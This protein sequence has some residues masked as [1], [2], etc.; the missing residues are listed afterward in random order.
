MKA[1]GWPSRRQEAT[2]CPGGGA[3]HIAGSSSAQRSKACGQPVW[4]GSPRTGPDR[5]VTIEDDAAL[6]RLPVGTGAA[7]RSASV[8]RPDEEGV[9]VGNLDDLVLVMV[10]I[11]RLMGRMTAMSRGSPTLTS[12][13][14]QVH[15]A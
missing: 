3:S 6:R 2:W 13:P 5:G 10:A 14:S 12:W 4:S 9:F 7:D 15:S 11:Q 1:A 8:L